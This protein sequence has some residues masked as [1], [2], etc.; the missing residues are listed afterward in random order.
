MPY[1]DRRPYVVADSLTELRGPT[2]GTV[3][4]P[5]HL[6]WSGSA[7][8]NLDRP[9]RLASMYRTVLVEAATE[10]DLRAW[11][12]GV[13]LVGLWRAMW[14]PARLRGLWENRFPELARCVGSAQGGGDRGGGGGDKGGD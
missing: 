2:S 11:L 9:A 1:G 12:D 3:V 14:L 13:L 4:L 5:R 8:H 7:D 10:D 6:D